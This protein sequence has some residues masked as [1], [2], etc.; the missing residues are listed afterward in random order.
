MLVTRH[1]VENRK[2]YGLAM[3]AMGGL[4]AAWFGFIVSVERFVPLDAFDQYAAYYWG[5]YFVGCLYASTIFSELSSKAQ[6]INWLSVPASQLEKLLC[7]V[8][9]CML[10]F[11]V[12]YSLL[13]YLVD[14]P[15]VRLAG[16]IIESGHRI[17]PGTLIRVVP[18]E[19]LNVFN[20]AG[21]PQMERDTHVFIYGFFSVQAAFMLGSVYF[22]R[23]SF[24]KT[25]I[26]VLLLMLVT[27]VFI[28]KGVQGHLPPHWRMDGLVQWIQ[29][30]D[31]FVQSAL[32]R[33][34]FGIEKILNFL[35][36]FGT[37]VM[38]LLITYFRLK[39]KEV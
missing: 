1:W 13:F 37:P 16:H 18:T 39:E 27:V 36:M 23:Y 2:R 10:L 32:V 17:Y 11:F 9:F 7:A 25:I 4:L 8:F 12:S 38:L 24:I 33:L 26:A 20:G 19:V 14:I 35:L 5:L 34:P 30:K 31:M 15:M 28:T 6:G 21:L 29:S 22:P 3:L